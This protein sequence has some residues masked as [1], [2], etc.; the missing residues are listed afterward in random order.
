MYRYTVGGF[1]P[2]NWGSITSGI[3][4][5]ILTV[6]YLSVLEFNKLKGLSMMNKSFSMSFN[7]ILSSHL[8]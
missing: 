6:Y 2:V 4:D 8:I 5:W 1:R 7:T 3:Q